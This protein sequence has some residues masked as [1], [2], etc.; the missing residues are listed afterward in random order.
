MAGDGIAFF[1]FRLF[2]LN[3]ILGRVP[4]P[5]ASFEGKTVII[6]GANTGLG[7]EAARHIIKLGAARLIIAVRSTEKGEAAK[8]VLAEST[9]CDPAI[10]EVWPVDLASYASVKAF[11]ARAITEL[12]RIDALIENA[13]IASE[14]W[15]WAEDNESMVTVNVVSTFLLALLLLPKLRE[16]AAR[17]NT[18]PNL[19]VVSSDMHY[20]VDFNEKDAPEGI[21]NSLNNEKGADMVSRYPIT[22]LLEVFIVREMAAR[23]PVELCPVTINTTN[24]G[25]C[26]SGLGGGEE[27]LLFKVG[28]FLFA[29]SAEVG[30]RNLVYSASA[31]AETHGQYL[32]RCKIQQPATIV[33]GPRG[34]TTQERVWDEL[35][36]KLEKIQPGIT[37]NL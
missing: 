36:A 16:T 24:P 1:I 27:G 10:L 34:K 35:I 2:I 25:L 14:K 17:Y 3:Q 31:G 37:G 28:S 7:F 4:R 29:R 26:S 6:T 22:K 9:G 21:F 8:S 20:T 15:S 30:S 5:T 11:A 19:T 32:D 12:P 13:G 18:R 33:T 23:R